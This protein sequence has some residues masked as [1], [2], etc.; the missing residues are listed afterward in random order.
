VNDETISDAVS[1]VIAGQIIQGIEGKARDAILKRSIVE[2]LKDWSFRDAVQKAVTAKAS[3]IAAK[4]VEEEEWA[5]VITDAVL[6]GFDMYIA[7]LPNAV[8]D[9]LIET[10]H[11]KQSSSGYAS[12][13][14]LLKH[15]KVKEK[16]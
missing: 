15:L 7:A 1:K 2:A 10:M 5:R 11:G 4:M 6:S 8:R 3:K 12:C 16:P 9:M 14:E 13:A